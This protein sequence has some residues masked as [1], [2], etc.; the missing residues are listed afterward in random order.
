MQIATTALDEVETQIAPTQDVAVFD[1]TTASTQA[2]T[3]GQIDAIIT[4]LPTTLYLAAVEVPGTVVGQLP[5]AR[6]PLTPGDSCWRRTT[7]WSAASTRHSAAITES[8]ELSRP[9]PTSG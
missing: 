2:L 5:A 7:R 1:D 3:N 9:S 6:R 8:G 4:D